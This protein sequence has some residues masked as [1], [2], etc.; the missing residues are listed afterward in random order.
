MVVSL[1]HTTAVSTGGAAH[2]SVTVAQ[3]MIALV[4]QPFTT[5]ATLPHPNPVHGF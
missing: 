5:A 2:G 1:S 4:P 3:Y